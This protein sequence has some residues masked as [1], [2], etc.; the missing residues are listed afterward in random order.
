VPVEQR[1]P[2]VFPPE[3]DEVLP[4]DEEEETGVVGG[5][6]GGVVAVPELPEEEVCVVG[7]TVF[8]PEEEEVEV[9]PLDEEEEDPLDEEEGLYDPHKVVLATAPLF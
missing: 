1:D 8:P 6:V 9:L 4:L 7:G 5:V 3:D 2:L